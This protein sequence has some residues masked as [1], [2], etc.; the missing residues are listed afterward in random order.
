M[1]RLGWLSREPRGYLS[2][3]PPPVRGSGYITTWLSHRCRH[4]N[5]EPGA[6]QMSHLAASS[7]FISW[8]SQLTRAELTLLE[9]GSYRE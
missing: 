6:C 2:L 4:P 1:V 8:R 3:P 9:T 5:S 7:Q